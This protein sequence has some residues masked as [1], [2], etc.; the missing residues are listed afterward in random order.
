[1]ESRTDWGIELEDRTITPYRTDNEWEDY[2]TSLEE[3][4][5]VIEAKEEAKAEAER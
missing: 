5:Y 3:D 2:W 1:M 4:E